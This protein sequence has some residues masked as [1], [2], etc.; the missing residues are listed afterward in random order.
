METKLMDA[1]LGEGG[2][3]EEQT[4]I[5]L[6]LIYSCSDHPACYVDSGQ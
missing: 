4:Q 3:T 1:V 2:I 6:D 5:S